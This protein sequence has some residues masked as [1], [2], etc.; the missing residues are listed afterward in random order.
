MQEQTTRPRRGG[1]RAA[2]R[3][4]RTA[5]EAVFKPPLRRRL[6][7][8]DAFPEE[9]VEATHARQVR[10]ERHEIGQAFVSV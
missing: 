4:A 9:V 8:F 2:K 10:P 7:D 6:K 1:A 5:I 3:A